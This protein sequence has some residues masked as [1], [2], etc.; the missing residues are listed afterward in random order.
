[1][2]KARRMKQWLSGNGVLREDSDDEL[3]DD[4]IPWEWVYADASPGP[5]DDEN[6]DPKA[7]LAGG[8]TGSKKRTLG[9]AQRTIVGARIGKFHCRVGDTVLL[10]ANMQQAWVGIIGH[11]FEDADSGEKMANFMW[12]SAEQEIRN[13]GK[14][15][16]DFCEVSSAGINPDHCIRATG[17]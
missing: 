8:K 4:D 5:Q 15:R 9:D 13:R 17:R 12:F 14:K 1:M 6:I 3:G 2:R 7:E 10:K 11:F 16:T